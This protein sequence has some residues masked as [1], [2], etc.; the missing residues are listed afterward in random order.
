MKN[1]FIY[2][3]IIKASKLIYFSTLKLNLH[4]LFYYGSSSDKRFLTSSFIS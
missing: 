3:K 2:I 4:Y 1:F